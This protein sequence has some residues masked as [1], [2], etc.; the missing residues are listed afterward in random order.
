MGK[1]EHEEDPPIPSYEEATIGGF[2]NSDST[3]D[4]GQYSERHGLLSGNIED[5]GESSADRGQSSRTSN[6]RR[7]TVRSVRSSIDSDDLLSSSELN[8][9]G[10]SGSLAR[11]FFELEIEDPLASDSQ[12]SI[13]KVFL[14]L[15]RWPGSFLQHF[16]TL[17]EYLR[18]IRFFLP[19]IS[20]IGDRFRQNSRVIGLQ[21][22]RFFALLFILSVIY[23]VFVSE[24]TPFGKKSKG[25]HYD[26]E[27]IK[28]FVQ[29]KLD[30]SYIET[31][32]E[33]LSSYPHLAGT[34]GDLLLAKWVQ[35]HFIQARMDHTEIKE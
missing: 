8:S 2:P 24:I 6:Y 9:R 30:V 23:F 12:S 19:S 20:C 28:T 31:Y 25:E 4:Y 3:P 35:N 18:N 10:S 14:R 11:E 15:Q 5:S 17:R 16:P 27:S 22:I 7:P 26:P 29:E 33:H 34:K 13:S 32:L 1:L 21:A